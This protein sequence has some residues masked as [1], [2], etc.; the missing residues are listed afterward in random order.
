[1]RDRDIREQ[2]RAKL[3]LHDPKMFEQL[4]GGLDETGEGEEDQVDPYF[5]DA[6]H[7]MPGFG[8]KEKEE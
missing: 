4:L 7:T 8:T 2:R 5:G 1:M 3:L 6:Y